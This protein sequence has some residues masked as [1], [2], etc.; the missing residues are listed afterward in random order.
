M[1]LFFDEGVKENKIVMGYFNMPSPRRFNHKYIF[2]NERKE[3]LDKIV[4]NAKR[5]L[6]MLPPEE[7]SYEEKIRG[8]FVGEE[9]HLKRHKEDGPRISTQKIVILLAAL[10]FLLHYLVTGS[11]TL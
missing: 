3:K 5:D 11:W 2:V 4:N 7:K 1:I 9:S 6:G 10:L 8:A